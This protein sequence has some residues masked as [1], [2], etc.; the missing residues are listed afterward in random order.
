MADDEWLVA[1]GEIIAEISARGG[2]PGAQR[3]LLFGLWLLFMRAPSLIQRDFDEIDNSTLAAGGEEFGMALLQQRR[4]APPTDDAPQAERV[5][6]GAAMLRGLEQAYMRAGGNMRA[7]RRAAELETAY[8]GEFGYVMPFPPA[9]R[10]SKKPWPPYFAR[11][12]LAETRC[13]RKQLDTGHEIDLVIGDPIGRDGAIGCAAALFE[14]VVANGPDGAPIDFKKVSR[15][16]FHSVT[17]SPASVAPALIEAMAGDE[18]VDV[19]VFPELTMPPERLD[20]LVELLRQ[21]P[22]HTG[23]PLRAPALVVGGSWHRKT[24]GGK[25]VNL[26][27]VLRS[28]GEII[29]WHSKNMPFRRRASVEDIKPSNQILVVAT[30]T[31][32]AAIATCLDFCQETESNVYADL[33]VDLVLIPSMGQQTTL[34]SH[35]GQARVIWHRRKAATFVAQQSDEESYGYVYGRPSDGAFGER[36]HQQISRRRFVTTG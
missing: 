3:Q 4:I 20:E 18:S 13:L 21:K 1:L 30:P 31:L 28:N 8:G 5:R 15:F 12:G 11:R 27:P 32:T 17:L 23:G 14:S 16:L 7:P 24:E 2:E 35:D 29:G 10:D 19:L 33:D 22:W 34:E 25:H 26:A 36:V 9:F 6:F